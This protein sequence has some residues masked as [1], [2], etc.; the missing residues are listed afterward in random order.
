MTFDELII[1][2][3]VLIIAGSE[4][5]ATQLSG[6]TYYLCSNPSVLT[7]LKD[8][9][10]G[11]FKSEADINI[12]STNNLTYLTAVLQESQR[13]YP[14]SAG[15]LPRVTPP[16]GCTIAGRYVSGNTSVSINHW[17][18]YHASFNFTRPYDFI[19]ERWL[20]GKEWESDKRKIVQPFSVGPRNCIG[21]NLAMAEMRV[22]LTRLVWGFEM[23]LDEKS[24][25]WSRGQ[26][27]F[28][29]YDK[30]SLWVR[31][32]PVVRE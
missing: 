4:T 26:K 6:V 13:L 31:L 32:K 3:I 15:S 30:P 16:G 19:P 2:T 21:R 18:A 14:A 22:L 24:T 8:E 23:V 17:S 7:K 27:V 29:V 25:G 10:R 20:G 9:I 1:T 5:V 11:S 12:I 28:L